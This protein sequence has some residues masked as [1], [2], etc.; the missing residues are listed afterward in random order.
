MV[1][2]RINVII[3]VIIAAADDDDDDDD[4]TDINTLDLYSI[5]P[6]RNT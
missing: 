1:R 4:D 3:M 6:I 5:A 2:E